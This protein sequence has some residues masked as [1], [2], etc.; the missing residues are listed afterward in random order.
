M[1]LFSYGSNNPEQLKERLNLYTSPY[2][3]PAHLNNYILFFGGYSTKWK[4]AVASITPCKNKKVYGI[5]TH[6]TDEQLKILDKYEIGYKRDNITVINRI[7][8]QPYQAVVYIKNDDIQ[9]LIHPSIDY[10]KAVS[11]TL[12]H[13]KYI[14]KSIISIYSYEQ[15]SK[16][17]KFQKKL[18]LT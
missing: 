18:K 10:I 7:D 15:Y 11:K 4:G 1:Y 17:F 16:K 12:S 6:T 5:L 14:N 9:Y 2:A 3:I 13:I 8:M